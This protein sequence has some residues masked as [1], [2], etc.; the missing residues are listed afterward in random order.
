MD[1]FVDTW[2]DKVSPRTLAWT[3]ALTPKY[4]AMLD[5]YFWPDRVI[6]GGGVSKRSAKYW[7]FLESGADLVKA[8]YLNTSG[9]IGAA[10]AAG[11]AAHE[12]QAATKPAPRRRSTRGSAAK[13]LG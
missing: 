9:I 7:E 10:Y 2:S 4:L 8:K 13:K 3:Q 5:F 6:L 11:L 1:A 12:E